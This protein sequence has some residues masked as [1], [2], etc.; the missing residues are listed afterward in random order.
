MSNTKSC[1]SE[2]DPARLAPPVLLELLFVVVDEDMVELA[3]LTSNRRGLCAVIMDA[4][5]TKAK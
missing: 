5:A 4:E 2:E 3:C 1:R